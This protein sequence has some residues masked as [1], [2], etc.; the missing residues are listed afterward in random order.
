[1]DVH[2]LAALGWFFPTAALCLVLAK[3][4]K[5]IL[6]G[7]LV[8]AFGEPGVGLALYAVLTLPGFFLHEGAHALTALLLGVPLRRVVWI[9]RRSPDDQ[10]VGAFTLVEPRDRLRMA[11]IALAPLAAG[12]LALGLLTGLMGMNSPDPYPWVR[13]REWIEG[14]DRRAPGFWASV[15]LIWTIGSHMAPSDSDLRI[16]Q[17]GALGLL[18]ALLLLGWILS[19]VGNGS[20]TLQAVLHR[21]GDSLA[22]GAGLNGLILLALIPLHSMARRD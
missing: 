20:S 16:I 14:V 9:P 22:I 11:L 2:L 1:M 5:R 4:L 6:V 10:A 21:L 8:Q 17:R 15:Y 19:L 7:L 12:A 13:L 18:I 3:R